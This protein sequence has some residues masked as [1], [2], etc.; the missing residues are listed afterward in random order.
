MYIC[1]SSLLR[2]V[3]KTSSFFL[4]WKAF[5]FWFRREFY[6]GTN[7]VHLYRALCDRS[8]LI[9][10]AVLINHFESAGPSWTFRWPGAFSHNFST[11]S[12]KCPA[13]IIVARVEGLHT[14]WLGQQRVCEACSI[15]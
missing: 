5:I 3:D 13:P 10:S 7:A 4:P 12:A 9:S 8:L 14:I 2:Q 11:G 15:A 1:E 6:Y